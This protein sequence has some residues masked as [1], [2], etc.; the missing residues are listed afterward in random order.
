MKNGFKV[1][2]S[3]LHVVEPP[4]LWERYTEPAFRDRAPK[5]V[6][7]SD[8]ARVSRYLF[9]GKV[10]PTCDA[11]HPDRYVGM[12]RR[13]DAAT[14]AMRARGYDAVSQIEAMDLEGIDVAVLYGTAAL[15]VPLGMNGVD[16]KL[17]AAVCRA[18]N[19][20][21]ADFCR[22]DPKR[23][24]MAAMLPAHDVS[25]A[26]AEARR[27]VKALGAAAVYL[28]PNFVNG[29]RWHDIL[30]RPLWAELQELNVAVGFHEGTG[31]DLI[32]DGSEFGDNRL[33]RH[34]CS[35]PIG[36]MKAMISMICGGVFEAFPRLRVG[37]LEANT[38]WVPFWLARMERDVALYREWDAPF[39]TLRPT[40]YFRRNCWVG[41]EGEEK[42]LRYVVEEIGDT[43]I[44]FSTDYPHHDSEF[45]HSVEEFLD[46]PIPEAS[47]GKILWDSCA[48][49]YGLG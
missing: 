37:F 16:P 30:Y 2:D 19:D 15:Y 24:K 23:L 40:E 36:M 12:S 33:M 26:V 25:E 39:L 5:V 14:T 1:M 6:R 11:N 38:G 10:F 4:D 42:E 27:A 31:S 13:T 22:Q 49:L 20:W 47:K 43:N 45:P 44:V 7:V 32:Q 35:H 41:S 9:E 28:R 48:R 29:V 34:A 18:Y 46:L 3:D 17:S 8:T 21:L